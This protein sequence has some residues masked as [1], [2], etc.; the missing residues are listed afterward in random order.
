MGTN[1]SDLRPK[2]S[3]FSVAFWSLL[4]QIENPRRDPHIGTP[5]H[6]AMDPQDPNLN[7]LRDAFHQL[8]EGRGASLVAMLEALD[9]QDLDWLT[10][11]SWELGMMVEN[12]GKTIGKW[13]LHEI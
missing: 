4:K 3:I 12:H 6:V 2:M 1:T 7:A 5:T 10:I 8:V 11:C 13:W 9:L